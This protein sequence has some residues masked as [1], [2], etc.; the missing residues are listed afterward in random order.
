M[1]IEQSKALITVLPIL[2]S[3][4]L[5]QFAPICDERAKRNNWSVYSAG[6]RDVLGKRSLVEIH[7]PIVMMINDQHVAMHRRNA[8]VGGEADWLPAILGQP[9]NMRSMPIH[10]GNADTWC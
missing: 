7:N 4:D 3:S 1:K 10:P 6:V 5:D 2:P 8:S 9:L